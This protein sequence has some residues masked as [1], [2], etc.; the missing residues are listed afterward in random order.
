MSEFEY[1]SNFDHARLICYRYPWVFRK[2][3]DMTL[4]N[5]FWDRD[6]DNLNDVFL[7]PVSI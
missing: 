1:I 2:N 5:V 4:Y 3:D 6:F 7:N